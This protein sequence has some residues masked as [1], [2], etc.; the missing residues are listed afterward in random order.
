VAKSKANKSET[1]RQLMA[2]NPKATAAELADMAKAKG[3]PVSVQM[4]YNVRT[5]AAKKKT[6]TKNADAT[7]GHANGAGSKLKTLVE[8][9]GEEIVLKAAVQAMGTKVGKG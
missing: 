2:D 8:L 1:I 9:F 4:V 5:N 7:P 6:S 3:V